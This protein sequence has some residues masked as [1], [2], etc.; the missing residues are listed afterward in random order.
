MHATVILKNPT[1]SYLLHENTFISQSYEMNFA[2]SSETVAVVSLLEP[3]V[4][5]QGRE[6]NLRIP[7]T[8]DLADAPPYFT[9]TDKRIQLTQR[10]ISQ[11]R[12]ART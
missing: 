8:P 3:W 1:H 6:P 12:D 7:G 11:S 9:V 2:A 10:K 5:L 4:R